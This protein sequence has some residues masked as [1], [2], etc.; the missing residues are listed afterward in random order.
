MKTLQKRKLS[1]LRI[2]NDFDV[3]LLDELARRAIVPFQNEFDYIGVRKNVEEIEFDPPLKSYGIPL[4]VLGIMKSRL[5]R[6]YG[7]EN[8]LAVIPHPI[9]GGS[10]GW[11]DGK[12]AFVS[13]HPKYLDVR[14]PESFMRYGEK[15]A[16][17]ELGHLFNLMHHEDR[18]YSNGDKYCLMYVD[19]H[20]RMTENLEKMGM[21]FCQICKEAIRTGYGT[22]KF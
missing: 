5:E 8:I 6:T 10:P 11:G 22:M 15:V 21:D 18:T 20:Y 12:V 13:T 9:M 7:S 3:H 14:N 16:A 2:N 17:H 4:W 1:I 19:N